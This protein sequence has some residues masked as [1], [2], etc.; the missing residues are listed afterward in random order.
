MRAMVLHS[1]KLAEASPL[2]A[3]DVPAPKLAAGQLL[4]RVS[5]CGVCHTDLHVVE[6][7]LPLP[8]LPLIPGHQIVG[9]VA[10]LGEGATGFQV[11]ERVGVP[12][13]HKTCGVCDYC[14]AGSENLCESAEFTGY[15]VDGGFAEFVV[16]QAGFVYHLPAGYDDLQAAPLLCAG[17]IGFR[18]L[19]LSG[20][21]PGGRLAMYGFGGSAHVAIQVARQWG[22]E[23]D[24]MTRN[25][26]HRE[27]ALS[28]GASWTGGAEDAPPA[29]HDAAVIFA[30]AGGLVPIALRNLRRG[31]TVALAGIYMTPIPEMDYGSLLY[32][33]RSVKSVANSTRQDVIDLL[34]LAPRVPIKTSV[35]VFEL[36]EANA[37]LLAMKESR[38]TGA[39]VLKIG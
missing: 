7:E 35:E 19:R 21:K 13:L 26:A 15:H 23:V 24:V 14:A 3:E 9:T 33:E 17:V 5:A 20:V 8:K 12:W 28:L 31:G 16:A 30:P 38:I 18:A 1:P 29:K 36:T 4:I 34:D 22:C 10:G 2:T 6:G 32:H 11:G 25:P 27:H 39:G 37:A